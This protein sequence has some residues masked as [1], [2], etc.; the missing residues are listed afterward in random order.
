MFLFLLFLK[1]VPFVAVA[2]TKELY[3]QTREE[4]SGG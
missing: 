1:F 4:G 2:E 3:Q